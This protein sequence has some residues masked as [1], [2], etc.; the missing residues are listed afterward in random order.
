MRFREA[1]LPNVSMTAMKSVVAAG[2]WALPASG[3]QSR[4]LAE[5]IAAEVAR[6]LAAGDFAAIMQMMNDDMARDLPAPKLAETWAGIIKQVGPLREAGSPWSIPESGYVVARAPL[7]F[8]RQILDLKVAVASGTIVG[9]YFS[10]H[11]EAVSSWR[12]PPYADPASFRE[13]EV[14][15][16]PKIASL[17]GTLTLPN[18][19][20]KSPAII[21]VH[22]SGPQDRDE[23]VGP[24]RPFRDLAQGL[25]TR[26]I[27]VLRYDKRTKVYPA[28][29]AGLENPTVKQ[30]TLDDVASA[31]ELL[32]ERPEIDSAGI[33]VVGHSLGGALAP[34]IAEA[35]PSIAKLVILAGAA[36]ALPDIIVE[37][38]EYISSMQD[39]SRRVPAEAL[40]RLKDDAAKAKAARLGDKG[41]DILG[42]PPSYWADLNVYDPAASAARLT[43]PLLVLQ[44]GRD[45]QVTADDYTRFKQALAGRPN[46]RCVWLPQLNHLFIAREARSVPSEY[47]IPG[48]VDAEVI[49]RIAKFAR[50]P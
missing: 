13:I 27:A 50:E 19:A 31:I 35:N 24:N 25:A 10:R 14:S 8:D 37:Q 23:S 28:S 6:D 34:R 38:T 16:G 21:L 12:A 33:I 1:I 18:G 11:E 29:F 9:L 2:L 49:D 48:H 22:G 39:P 47:Q 44:G 40:A 43:L 7:T 17:P 36:R 3:A 30:E 26:G 5:E 41:P 45:Y 4:D 46:A 15:I 32:R 42:A 20:E